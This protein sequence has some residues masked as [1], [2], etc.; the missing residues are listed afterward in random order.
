MVN[1][2]VPVAGDVTWQASGAC[3]GLDPQLFYPERGAVTSAVRAL[4]DS[5]R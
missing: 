2:R 5:C 4:C 1:D 3:V